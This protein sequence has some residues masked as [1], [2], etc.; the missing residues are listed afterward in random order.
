[1]K[2]QQY[3]RICVRRSG[4]AIVPGATDEEALENAK[5]L[6]ACDFD[7]EPVAPELIE[8]DAEII[9]VCGPAGETLM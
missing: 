3:R 4:Y 5:N 7:W 9:E 8:T 6:S 2:D 1:M